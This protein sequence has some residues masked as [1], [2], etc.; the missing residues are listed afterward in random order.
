MA[1]ETPCTLEAAGALG[2]DTDCTEHLV[3]EAT[4]L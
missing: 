1:G 3:I 2:G 4:A